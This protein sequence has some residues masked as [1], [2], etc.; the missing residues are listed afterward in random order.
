MYTT[1]KNNLLVSDDIFNKFKERPPL[2][3]GY[4]VNLGLE[5][6]EDVLLVDYYEG[7]KRDININFVTTT[8]EGVEFILEFKE[9]LAKAFGREQIVY[10]TNCIDRF[11]L[12]DRK[13]TVNIVG[14]KIV[15]CMGWDDFSKINK[16]F[17]DFRRE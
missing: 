14:I 7:F 11:R 9:R 3:E 2:K 4:W 10:F 8:L 1:L 17:S 13:E 16:V 12:D 5:D 15:R 6:V